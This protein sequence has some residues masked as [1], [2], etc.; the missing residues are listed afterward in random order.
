[1]LRKL[2]GGS[3]HPILA[4][5]RASNPWRQFKLDYEVLKTIA[6]VHLKRCLTLINSQGHGISCDSG[7]LEYVQRE[8][9]SERFGAR[10]VQNVAMRVLQP[11]TESAG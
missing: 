2:V 9:Y 5:G 1:M 8:G 7:V 3:P 11:L 6:E 10:R 4:I